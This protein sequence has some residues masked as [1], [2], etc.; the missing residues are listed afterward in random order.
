M[1]ILFYYEQEKYEKNKPLKSDCKLKLVADDDYLMFTS[2]F[3]AE[4]IR[5]GRM[6]NL[7]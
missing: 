4:Y 3:Y 6:N 7:T 2:E 1:E 5:M